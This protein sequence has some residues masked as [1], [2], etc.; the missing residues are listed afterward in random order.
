MWARIWPELQPFKLKLFFVLLAGVL[1]S[2]LKSTTGPLLGSLTDAWEKG[3]QELAW[4]IPVALA[5]GWLMIGAG[6]FINMFWTKYIVDTVIINL[7]RKL[8]DK[9]L[10]LSFSYRE[11][12]SKGS[13]GLISHLI[14]D[15]QIVHENLP[16]ISDLFSQPALVLISIVIIAFIDLKFLFMIFALILV[17]P[18]I[19]KK[20]SRSLRK[21]GH[22]NQQIMEELTSTLK[23][24]LDGAQV[25][26]SFN[27]EGEMKKRFDSGATQFLRTRRSILKREEA[28]GPMAES[29]LAVALATTLYILGLQISHSDGVEVSSFIEFIT[30]SGFLADGLKKSQ[31]AYIRLQQAAVAIKRMESILQAPSSETTS[32]KK[33]PKQKFPKNWSAIEYRNVSFSFENGRE[34]LSGL[35]FSIHRGEMLAIVGSSGSGKSTLVNL[36][37]RFYEPQWGQILIDEIPIT[38]IELKDLRK[39]IA[40]VTQDIFLFSDSIENNIRLGSLTKQVKQES[41][42][43]EAA[44]MANAHSF[45]SAIQ[46][47]YASRVGEKGSRLSGG[48]KQRIS[49]ARAIYKD[50]PILILDEA[51]SALDSESELEV[52]KGLDQLM[53]G[54]TSLVIAH[55]LSTL[56]KADRIL[57]LKDGA[58]FEQGRHEELIALS[59][60][61]A[62]FYQMQSRGNHKS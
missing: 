40:L 15:L 4:Q 12:L 13:G 10:R 7:R 16:R 62:R 46:G 44:E 24:S 52:Q 61:Y 20:F 60:E 31:Y 32:K 18:I 42:V 28:A 30:A 1:V 54:R 9:Y 48:E 36:L 39:N 57:V 25:I 41:G 8:M 2:G 21:Y 29:V 53:Q 47:S 45:I 23:E 17:I 6:R 3:N 55:R 51:T 58:I 50:A 11:S 19:L 27:L 34:V 56:V 38:E 5:C 22:R 14:N 35:N 49:I 59:G 26:Q 43:V 33:F 37:E